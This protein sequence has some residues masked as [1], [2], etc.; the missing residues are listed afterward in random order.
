[1]EVVAGGKIPTL[2]AIRRIEITEL[3]L[4]T[5]ASDQYLIKLRATGVCGT[6]L[7]LYES[8]WGFMPVVLGHDAVGEIVGSGQRVV[9]DPAI[10]CRRCAYCLAGRRNACPEYRFLG[11]TAPGTFASFLT[12]PKVNAIP[13][14]DEL[15]DEAGTVLEPVCVALH[16][17]ERLKSVVKH[18]SPVLVVGGGPIGIVAARV[19]Q[20]EGYNVTVVE[21]VD[22]RRQK[23]RSWGI[24]CI[25]P[26]EITPSTSPTGARAVA[27]ETSSSIPGAQLAIEWMGFGGVFA[28][29][30]ASSLSLRIADLL[31]KDQSLIGIHGGGG[32]Y[33]EAVEL[34]ASGVLP[35]GELVSHRRPIADLEEV[36]IE[37]NRSPLDVYRT[38]LMHS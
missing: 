3:A 11:M 34:V 29:I 24:T 19:L 7:H 28:S 15:S 13:I 26:E 1:M 31:L 35:V 5:P 25:S 33:V 18:D 2:T 23:V 6:D 36:I 4:P 14:P 8:D 27:V 21:T 10:S 17:K 32:R 30:G 38:V 9:L 12:I 16:L 37:T 22:S 20:L